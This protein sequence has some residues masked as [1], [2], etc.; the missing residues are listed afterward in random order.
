MGV[1]SCP[2]SYSSWARHT[3]MQMSEN[4]LPTTVVG[5]YIQPEW[6]VA[7][8]NL[9]NR[10]PPRVRAHEIWKVAEVDLEE[11]QIGVVNSRAADQHELLCDVLKPL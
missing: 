9:K 11:A 6:L 3:E 2:P 10:L 4:I 7:R 5:S 1:P 8:T